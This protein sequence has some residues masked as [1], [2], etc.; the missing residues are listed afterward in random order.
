MKGEDRPT[1][2]IMAVLVAALPKISPIIKFGWWCL[3]AATATE[4]SG[5]LVPMERMRVPTASGGIDRREESWREAK[6]IALEER[7]TPITPA[8]IRKIEF[9]KWWF[10]SWDSRGRLWG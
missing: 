6:T 4:I 3:M 5:R 8:A 9:K 1:R 10:I 2:A 7:A